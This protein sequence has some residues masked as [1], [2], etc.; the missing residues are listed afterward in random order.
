MST[1]V[2][3]A[4]LGVP[5]KFPVKAGGARIPRYH[6]NRHRSSLWKRAALLTFPVDLAGYACF[7]RPDQAHLMTRF[8]F[9]SGDFSHADPINPI[10]IYLPASSLHDVSTMGVG[11][12]AGLSTS[13]VLSK[14]AA[15]FL[16]GIH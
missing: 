15:Q 2:D 14:A 4:V 1:R 13:D 12:G 8:L 9:H 11:C 7:Q 5:F 10:C 16:S 3:D 6:G